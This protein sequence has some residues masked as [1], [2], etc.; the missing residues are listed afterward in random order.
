[1]NCG[2]TPGRIAAL[3]PKIDMIVD[4]C[5]SGIGTADGYD[6]VSRLAIPLPVQVIGDML[7]I[8]PQMRPNIKRWTDGIAQ[9]SVGTRARPRAWPS[10]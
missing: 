7:G 1:M 10:A 9:S 2:F 5:L 3:G 4:E 6:V 8:E